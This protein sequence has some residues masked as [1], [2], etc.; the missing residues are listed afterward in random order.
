MAVMLEGAE[1]EES[2]RQTRIKF[3]VDEALHRYFT[4]ISMFNDLDEGHYDPSEY[5]CVSNEQLIA[6]I[7]RH[8]VIIGKLVE[9]IHPILCI[10]ME[11]LVLNE[12][13]FQE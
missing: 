6:L 2:L 1:L 13:A 7:D 11:Q 12:D 5:R 8:D 4:G 10:A 3:L 9:H